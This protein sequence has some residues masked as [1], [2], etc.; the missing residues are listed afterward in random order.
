[1]QGD[2]P[3]KTPPDDLLLEQLHFALGRA[4]PE[5]AVEILAREGFPGPGQNAA[6]IADR[7]DPEF[8]VSPDFRCLV[9]FAQKVHQS[10]D[11]GGFIPVD[12]GEDPELVPLLYGI[13]ALE[14]EPRQPV[15]L[16]PAFPYR[17]GVR[18]QAPRVPGLVEQRRHQFGKRYRAPVFQAILE[19]GSCA[20]DAFTHARIQRPVLVGGGRLALW[21]DR[22]IWESHGWE[23]V[24]GRFCGR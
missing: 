14:A 7:V 20:A 17:E 23:S 19:Q 12:S 10:Q 6:G 18:T 3:V 4:A 24:R 13:C 8:E 2:N 1:M 11:S 21:R 5:L 15:R 9:Q 16:P 22:L